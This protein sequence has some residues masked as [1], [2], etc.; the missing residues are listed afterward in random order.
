MSPA[1]LR[2]HPNSVSAESSVTTSMKNL[3]AGMD[4]TALAVPPFVLLN[5]LRAL[6]PQFAEVDRSGNFSQQ[7]RL[8][9]ESFRLKSDADEA[10][11]QIVSALSA[12]LTNPTS[13]SV[14]DD[15][16]ALTL[17]QTL[18]TFATKLTASSK[19]LEQPDEPPTTRVDRS[20]KL[21]CNIS[22]STNYMLSGIIEVRTI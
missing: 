19:C 12:C 20:L 7:G 5:N 14:I 4:Q 16:M 1:D 18:G 10:W 11:T 21:E 2:Y 9:P 3:F 17:T 6:A 13:Q 22:V 8:T 15:H